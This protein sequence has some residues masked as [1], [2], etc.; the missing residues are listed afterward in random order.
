MKRAEC[1]VVMFE[2][3]VI[4]LES[5]FYCLFLLL[6]SVHTVSRYTYT[7]SPHV[8]KRKTSSYHTNVSDRWWHVTMQKK[9]KKKKNYWNPRVSLCHSLSLSVTYVV[10]CIC[11]NICWVLVILQCLSKYEEEQGRTLLL[12]LGHIH[13]CFV[14]VTQCHISS[15]CM[16]PWRSLYPKKSSDRW[17]HVRVNRKWS[18]HRLQS[19][20]LCHMWT[21]FSLIWTY[22]VQ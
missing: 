16:L 8:V 1:A 17:S 3:I 22:W 7:A 19:S 5:V 14:N 12:T 21:W 2:R 6:I 10:R 4:L 9:T 18:K 20:Q 11:Q 15:H 13:N